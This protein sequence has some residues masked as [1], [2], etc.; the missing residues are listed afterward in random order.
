MLDE[1]KKFIAKG[2]VVDMA[3]GIIIGAAFTAIVTSLVGDILNPVM[4]VI[5][6]GIDFSNYYIDLSMG[7]YE[8]LEAAKKAGA[9]LIMYGQFI[10]SIIKF[11]IVALVV[12]FLVKGVNRLK[13]KEEESAAKAPP[14]PAEEVLLL[15][16]IRDVL[17]K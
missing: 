6:G 11:L 5:I 12:F 9:P 10:N 1:F 4:G 15:R 7:K 17:K 14:K 2:N 3:V 13:T 8:S 16:E